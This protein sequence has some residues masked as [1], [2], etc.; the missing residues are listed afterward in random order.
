MT[1]K[2]SLRRRRIAKLQNLCH[3]RIQP[4]NSAAFP[5]SMLKERA[6]SQHRSTLRAKSVVKTS[7]RSNK[8]SA[9]TSKRKPCL[10]CSK[11]SQWIASNRR[12]SKSP[13]VRRASTIS[14]HSSRAT[15]IE[16]VTRR[17]CRSNL[18]LSAQSRDRT[19]RT[20]M[21]WTHLPRLSM[22]S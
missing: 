6:I 2:Q 8:T 17:E 22:S 14:T 1:K 15:R 5:P 19:T 18:P 7:F 9:N 3:K 21:T 13:T 11:T 16:I 20:T 12:L 10:S 4:P